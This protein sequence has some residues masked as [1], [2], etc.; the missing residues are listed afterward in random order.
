MSENMREPVDD[1][2]HATTQLMRSLLDRYGIVVA[3]V[4]MIVV[5]TLIKPDYFPTVGNLTN[6][7]R[8]ISFNAMLALGEFIVILTA[9]IDLSV[10]SVTALP[11]WRPW[12]SG[13]CVAC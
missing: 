8:Q 10:G 9:G 7:A 4:V 12:V 5:L 11:C 6:V 1:I 3:L 2:V 13:C